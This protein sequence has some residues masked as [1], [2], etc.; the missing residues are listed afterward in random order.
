MVGGRGGLWG[1]ESTDGYKSETDERKIERR[2]DTGGEGLEVV[3][4]GRRGSAGWDERSVEWGREAK[5]QVG[6][7]GVWVRR[8]G[9]WASSRWLGVVCSSVSRLLARG[10][11]RWCAALGVEW[12]R[13]VK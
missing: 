2:I 3:E 5:G 4:V 11:Y 10:G 8:A 6:G 13:R 9:C 7:S 12:C 1:C